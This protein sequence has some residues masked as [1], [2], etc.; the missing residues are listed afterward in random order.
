V[1]RDKDSCANGEKSTKESIGYA[2]AFVLYDFTSQNHDELKVVE[3]EELKILLG[4]CDEDGW[5]MAINLKGEKGKI[6]FE[7]FMFKAE[8][9]TLIRLRKFDFLRLCPGKLCQ[10]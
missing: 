2:K 7:I 10:N 5:V 4:G 6:K 3:G 9:V 1:I 8:M